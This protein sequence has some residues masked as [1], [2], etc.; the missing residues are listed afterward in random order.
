MNTQET[1]ELYAVILVFFMLVAAVG[2]GL[3]A[4]FEWV[5]RRTRP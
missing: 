5:W 2:A 4:V 1:G 3:N